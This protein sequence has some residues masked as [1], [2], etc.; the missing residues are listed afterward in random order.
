MNNKDSLMDRSAERH[1]AQVK[2]D[3]Q[4]QLAQSYLPRRLAAAAIDFGIISAG[5]L[6]IVELLR[7]LDVNCSAF[8][9]WLACC[10]IFLFRDVIGGRSPGKRIAGLR[11]VYTCNTQ[12]DAS[13][14]DMLRRSLPDIILPL[15][16]Y[17]LCSGKKKTGDRLARTCV[18]AETVNALRIAAFWLCALVCAAMIFGAHSIAG[19]SW[20]S[21][22]EAYAAAVE[23]L[24]EKGYSSDVAD[25]SVI[26]GTMLGNNAGMDIAV[27]GVRY[28]FVIQNI[29]GCWTVAVCEELQEG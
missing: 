4:N 22:T 7:L 18:T 17:Q 19:R 29:D 23:Y 2:A 21:N 10:F 16:L 20:L 6:I 14:P 28:I 27:N 15:S 12:T 11:V 26:G 1:S 5:G 24:E 9:F 8:L 13:I 25:C 3:R